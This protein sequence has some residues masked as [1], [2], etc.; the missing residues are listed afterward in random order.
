M[1]RS[2]AFWMMGVPMGGNS[3]T[4]KIM[5]AETAPTIPGTRPQNNDTT[6]T[7]CR[8]IIGAATRNSHPL[9]MKAHSN[10]AAPAQ[11]A[12][13]RQDLPEIRQMRAM[14]EDTL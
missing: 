5:P 8:Q 12:A 10:T 3:Q 6:I 4:L 14:V 9:F 13:A 1:T 7:A 2:E 11:T